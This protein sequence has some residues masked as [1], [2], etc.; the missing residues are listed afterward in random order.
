MT[1]SFDPDTPALDARGHEVSGFAKGGDREVVH[2]DRCS[3][4]GLIDLARQAI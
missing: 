2:L 4:S 1:L 3:K